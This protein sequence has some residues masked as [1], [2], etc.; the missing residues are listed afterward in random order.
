MHASA[1]L[2]SYIDPVSGVILL[3]LIIGGGIGCVARFRHRIWRF[4]SRWFSK[5]AV[6]EERDGAVPNLMP[7]TIPPAEDME[8]AMAIAVAPF[9][10]SNLHERREERK[11]A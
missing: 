5:R 2:F 10:Q 3:Q 11:A 8:P 9:A 1:S 6:A 7:L 4:I